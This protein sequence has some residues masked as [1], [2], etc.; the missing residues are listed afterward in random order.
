MILPDAVPG[1]A[2]LRKMRA[3]RVIVSEVGAKKSL[4]MEFIEYNDMVEA[5]ATY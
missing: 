2:C 5:L 3:R 4:E 1:V